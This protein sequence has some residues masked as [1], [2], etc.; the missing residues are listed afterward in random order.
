MDYTELKAF[1]DNKWNVAQMINSLFYKVESIV[2]N[3]EN[4]G[5]QH[6]LLFPQ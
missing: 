3:G 2:G 1:A 5:V 6:F 4:A